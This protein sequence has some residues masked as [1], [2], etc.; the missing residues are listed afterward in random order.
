MLGKK[1]SSLVLVAAI[2]SSSM[3][4]L[5]V[6]ADSLIANS[7][8]QESQLQETSQVNVSKFDIYYSQFRETYDKVFKMD[9][10]NIES[11]VS[12]GGN[13]R[14][15]VSTKNMLDGNLDTYWETGRHTSSSF[16]NELIFTLKEETELNRIAYRSA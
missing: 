1:I 9:N 7:V 13:L 15:S 16:N 4:P 3:T 11:V 2:T 8:I 6:F 5:N 12:I 14:D 10:L